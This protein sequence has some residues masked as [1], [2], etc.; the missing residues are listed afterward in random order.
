MRQTP[1]KY[2]HPLD[3]TDDALVCVPRNNEVNRVI[4]GIF[5]NEYWAVS[6]PAQVGKTTFLNQIQHEFP[7]AQYIYFQFDSPPAREQDFYSHI[8]ETICKKVAPEQTQLAADFSGKTQDGNPEFAFFKFLSSF[9]VPV[10]TRKIILMF[11]EIDHLPYFPTFLRIWRKV[12]HERFEKKI[13]NRY[14]IIITGSADLIELTVGPTS[15]FNI[16]QTLYIGDLSQEES[17]QL[18]SEPLNRLNVAIENRAIDYLISQT[19]GHPQLLQH[20]CHLLISDHSND[21]HPI[22]QAAID[23]TI[24]ILFKQ[25]KLLSKLETEAQTHDKLKDLIKA[26]LAGEEKNHFPYRSFSLSGTGPIREVNQRC[27]IRNPIFQRFL[28]LILSDR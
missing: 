13:L 1:Y 5:R 6:G 12:F 17:K 20:I 18:I 19:G 10:N 28:Q 7:G 8:I 11:D 22:D 2:T 27:V 24:E 25:S 26:I 15:P 3:P 4:E 16:A 21:N 23:K 14:V 9:T